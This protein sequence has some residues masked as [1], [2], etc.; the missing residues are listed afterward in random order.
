MN[1]PRTQS[2]FMLI[3]V[4]ISVLIFAV[5]VLALVSLQSA[6]TKAQT[7]AKVRS[8]AAN[9]A[10]ELV[11]MIWSDSGNLAGYSSASCAS[12]PQ[13]A[14][15]LNKVKLMLPSQVTNVTTNATTGKVT[16]SLAWT[17]PGGTQHQYVTATM[18]NP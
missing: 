7:E 11:G 16:I 9:L 1:S 10:S 2:G 6:M 5:G 14:G 13:C 4:M 8:D 3:E 15:W 12:T 18:V 17:L